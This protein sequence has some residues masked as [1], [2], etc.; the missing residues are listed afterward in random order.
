M[1]LAEAYVSKNSLRGTTPD[2]QQATASFSK[3][4]DDDDDDDGPGLAEEWYDAAAFDP[5]RNPLKKR[6]VEPD[7]TCLCITPCTRSTRVHTRTASIVH[8]PSDRVEEV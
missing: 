3:R 8:K 7:R 5:P 6:R 2:S 1:S 4:D